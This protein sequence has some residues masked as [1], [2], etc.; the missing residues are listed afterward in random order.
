MRTNRGKTVGKKRIKDSKPNIAVF[1]APLLIL[2][3]V[4]WGVYE[5]FIKDSSDKSD[6]ETILYGPINPAEGN[7]RATIYFDNSVSMKGYAN[8]NANQNIYLDVLS[9]LR[10]FYSNTNA[11][12]GGEYILGNELIDRIRLHRINF[13][14]E[15]LLYHD[16][17]I[18]ASQAQ[19]ELEDSL[20]KTLPLNFYLTDGIMSGSDEQIHKDPEYN[21]IHAQDLQN[22]IRQVLADK[23]SIGISVYQ[24]E[25]SFVGDYWSYDNE[26]HSLNNLRYF[27]VIAVGSR[28]ALSNFK[29]KVDSINSDRNGT[30]S[31][32]IP[33][34]Q[35]HAID[36]HVINTNLLVGPHGAVIF[37]GS[38]FT[39]KPKVINNQGGY[40]S[41][42]LDSK[43]FRNYYI[44]NMDVLASKS[45]VEIDGRQAKDVHVIW[46]E[47]AHA[48]TFKIP[49]AILAKENTICLTI[50]RL[51]NEWIY[52][53]STSD[54]KYMFSMPDSKTFL[55]D[56][57][58]QGIQSGVSGASDPNIYKTII[59]LK[60]E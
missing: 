18:I 22:Q 44:E 43:V 30:Y 31:K 21:K 53:S 9:D 38:E 33:I 48:F 2:L 35:W 29:Q 54:D 20:R 25:S 23:E 8:A 6:A 55:F 41:F 51:R 15:S 27:Y 5:L 45:I 1:V 3:L 17:D 13:S 47:N 56:K 28:P 60:Q 42:N 46:D 39:Y 57:F 34:A 58:M 26:H 52:Q 40:I 14:A 10:G 12:I 36:N 49:V 50:P 4:G 37:N 24:F 11:I 16:L 32:F 59:K 7:I 19:K